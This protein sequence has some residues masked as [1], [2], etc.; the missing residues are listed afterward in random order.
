[1]EE[2]NKNEEQIN[3]ENP[4]QEKIEIPELKNTFRYFPFPNQILPIIVLA[5][6]GVIFYCTSLYNEAALDDGIIIHQNDYVLQGAKGI[7][8]I[9]T[10]DAYDS[11]YRRMNAKDQLVGG[12]YRPL[13]I[14]SF[15]LEQEI[16]G[17]YENGAY[18]NNCWDLNNNGVGD[19]AEDLNKDGVYN[20]VDCQ[21]KGSFLRH[22]DNM[23]TY[24]LG[25]ILLYLVF[26]N[27]MF[28]ENQDMAFLSALIFLAHPVH[29]EVVANIRG[30][31]D[32]FSLI[33]ISL[34]FL[35]AFKFIDAK[36]VSS[37]IIAVVMF[38]LALL[39]KEYATI[40][41][42]LI[43]LAF[44]VFKKI[45]FEFK[46]LLPLTFVFLV[47]VLAMLFIKSQMVLGGTAH[48]FGQLRNMPFIYY[49]LIFSAVYFVFTVL[50]YRKTLLQK[51]LN[52]LLIC[53]Y[54]VFL[55]YVGLRFNAVGLA[56]G[57]PDTELLNN[58]YLLATGEENFATRIFVF[59]KY[60]NLAWFPKNLTVGY[61][62]D[63]VR[64]HHFTD[65]DFILS[66]ILHLALLFFGIKLTIKRH[67][68]G[69]A[70]ITYLAFLLLVSNLF[71]N[72][73]AVMIER[74][75]FHATIG[76]AIAAAW[77]ILNGFDKMQSMSFTA[78]RMA[79][80]SLLGIVL[81]LYGC[82]TWERNFDWKNDI[83]LFVKDVTT[84]TDDVLCLGN[85]GARWIDMADMEYFT[86]AGSNKTELPFST[87]NNKMLEFKVSE[88][89]LKNGFTKDNIILADKGEFKN[90]Q[91]LTQRERALYKGIG[92]LKHAVNLHPRYVNGYL[93]LGLAYYK[94]N[95]ERE[96]IYNW[97]MAEDLYPNNP[98]LRNYYIVYFNQLLQRGYKLASE[99]K[100][101]KSVYELNKCIILDKYNPEGWYNLGGAYFN[102]K[103]TSK[104]KWCWTEALKLNPNHE[105][106]L[107]SMANLNGK[108]QENMLIVR[109]KNKHEK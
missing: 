70:I 96:A 81:F 43:P 48:S 28:R 38:F 40:L 29:S 92:Y 61:S 15:A 103:N 34:T 88:E 107:K 12:R 58:P 104:A 10:R 1:M 89:E 49:G 78:R 109:D 36:K 35:F 13:A 23:W 60:F 50:V 20:E 94:L 97:K 27:H 14:V 102:L 101:E 82:K 8:K 16:I 17:K 22:F 69:F 66:A 77:L 73:G 90:E 9:M 54:G 52:T 32:I 79:M 25:C 55:F 72:L 86:N 4:V 59:L 83:T 21:V 2:E 6:V 87:Y 106:A 30:R 64:Y 47:C 45:D 5:L 67:V 76:F 74:W 42:G 99:G 53:F 85:A 57:V 24:I 105:M 91:N 41:L 93:N 7:K 100:F 31:Q 71:F 80:F 33:F 19:L 46:A 65:W 3:N 51:N 63:S 62:F 84:G 37:L 95:R 39:S 68:F 26:R 44:Y 108:T 75:M 11:F 18:S 98:Y 56:P